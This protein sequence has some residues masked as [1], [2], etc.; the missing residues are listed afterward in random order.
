MFRTKIFNVPAEENIFIDIPGCAPRHIRSYPIK[1]LFKDVSKKALEFA[2][3]I[4]MNLTKIHDILLRYESHEVAS[5]EI[6]R[7]LDLLKSLKENEKFFA[8]KIGQVVT[9]LPRNQPLYAFC[10]FAVVPSLMASKVQV[11]PPSAV[12]SFFFDLMKAL[13]VKS[14]MPNIFVSTKIREEFL[15]EVSA[16][17]FYPQTGESIPVTD[18]VIFTGTMENADKVRRSFD[19]DVLFIANGA[20]HNPMVISKD[21]NLKL[22]IESVLRIQLYNQGQ[23]CANANSI[24][25]HSAVYS[26]FLRLLRLELSKTKIGPY[27]NIENRVGPLS[28]AKSLTDVQEVLVRNSIWLDR[29]TPGVIKTRDC[30]VEPTIIAKPLNKGGNF[31]ETFAPIFFVQKYQKDSDLKDYFEDPRYSRNAMYVT[32][33]GK[34][35]YVDN[36]VNKKYGDGK[37][38]HTNETIIRNTDLHAPGVERGTQQYGGFGRGASCFSLHGL[39]HAKPTLP[40]RDIFECLVVP[41]LKNKPIQRGKSTEIVSKVSLVAKNHESESVIQASDTDVFLDFAPQNSADCFVKLD[42]RKMFS[43]LP[44][45]NFNYIKQLSDED[46]DDIKALVSF[47]MTK[48]FS[49][50][51]LETKIFLI[52][53]PLLAK[54]ILKIDQK[55]F[56]KNVYQLLLGRDSGPR[57][58]KLLFYSDRKKIMQLLGPAIE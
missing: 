12:H 19:T 53:K 13:K 41:N 54:P 52:A 1:I 48:D 35:T 22:A 46:S 31:S 45:P 58:A 3:H 9:F 34:S 56:F 49:L 51:E 10:C 30:I 2:S 8:R 47:Y 50:Q 17:N 15:Q 43:F 18:A 20:G 4:E 33:F 38:L 24:L 25:V 32:L 21:A 55:N 23:D 11:K 28:E 42:P 37:I 5:D 27:A 39:V 26:D 57:L 40:Q 44:K 16:I 36:L 6:A 7:S 29:S 14:F